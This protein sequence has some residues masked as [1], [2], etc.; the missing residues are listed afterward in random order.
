MDRGSLLKITIARLP[1]HEQGTRGAEPPR[2]GLKSALVIMNFQIKWTFTLGN[3][4][5]Q[6]PEIA[7]SM[8]VAAARR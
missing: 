4:A 5:E 1:P 6:L 3:E 2:F 8:T 7:A